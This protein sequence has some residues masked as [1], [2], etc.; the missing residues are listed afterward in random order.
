MNQR[1]WSQRAL[2]RPPSPAYAP[3][4]ALRGVAIDQA[5]AERQH[6]AYVAALRGCG[7]EVHALAPDAARFD[8]VFVEDTA[9]VWGDRALLTRMTPAREGE[10]GAVAEALRESH[11][12]VRLPEGALLEG[13]D[14]LHAEGVTFVGLSS[15]TNEAGAAA[16]E[17][18]VG[19]AGRRVVRVHVEQCLHLKTGATW[20]GDGTMLVAPSLIDAG[21]FEG[22][23]VIEVEEAERG[24]ANAIRLERDV[25]M[26]AG[27]PRA[28]AR[29]AEFCSR[30]GLDLTTLDVSEFEKGDGS[31]TC[32][33][34]LW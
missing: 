13:G 10:Q 18:L 33:S 20:L 24:T 11:E 6:G 4:Y 17:A 15:R 27:R 9:V 34:I 23:E 7:L 3:T 12:I 26:A 31:L 14:V 2:V 30:R 16:V 21:A 25:L 8:S 1:A 22:L 32:M 28:Q 19:G 5:L 29:L